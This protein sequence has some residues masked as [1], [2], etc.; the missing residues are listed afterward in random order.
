VKI[1][2]E[3]W[4]HM[5]KSIKSYFEAGQNII[6]IGA[7][8]G[9][10][11]ALSQIVS[12]LPPDYSL[13]VIIVQHRNEESK[14][15][16]S[17]LQ[18]HT[19][20]TVREPEDKEPILCGTIY[21]APPGYHLMLERMFFE[22]STEGRVRYSRPSIDVLFSSAA[23]NFGKATIGIILTGANQDGA[24]GLKRIKQ[25]GGFTIVQDPATAQMAI[26]PKAA[27]ETGKADLVLHLSE[28]GPYLADITSKNQDLQGAAC[29]T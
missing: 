15:L 3:N 23:E 29:N 24:E 25:R 5:K 4:I 16:V 18:Q 2:I 7:S 12:S 22:L 13:P 11:Q 26:M 10:L 28:I 6:V 21:V 20:L 8:M 14:D 9:G 27:L 1:I 17:C 19:P